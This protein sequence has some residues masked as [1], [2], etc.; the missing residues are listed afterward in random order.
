MKRRDLLKFIGAVAAAFGLPGVARGLRPKEHSRIGENP[1]LPSD[2]REALEGLPNRMTKI[3]DSSSGAYWDMATLPDRIDPETREP[4][5][6][7]LVF[8]SETGLPN[9]CQIDGLE[10]GLV[11]IPGERFE[12]EPFRVKDGPF[13][14]D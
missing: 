10:G 11:V 6:V 5:Q 9:H 4:Y 7:W 13:S 1:Y 2:Y 14:F 12:V 8:D 3:V